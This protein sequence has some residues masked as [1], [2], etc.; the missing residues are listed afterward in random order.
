MIRVNGWREN[1][2]ALR[3]YQPWPRYYE[4]RYHEM[5]TVEALCRLPVSGGTML[6]LGCGNAFH[7]YLFSKSFDEIIAT[8]LYREDPLT[9]TIGLQRAA[10]V[11]RILKA[12]NLHIVGALADSLPLTSE[13]V[14]FVFSSNVLEHVPARQA[15]IREI[16][17][18]LR[19][20]AVCLT[21]VP[22]AMERVYNLPISYFMV[23]RSMCRGLMLHLR[24]SEQ[25]ASETAGEADSRSGRRW[26]VMARARRF[27]AKNYPTFPFPKPH[28][29]YRSS[30]EEFM[31]HRPGNWER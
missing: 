18:V 12:D 5:K 29:E 4:F 24:R 7:S 14:D 31:A 19:P 10:A 11:R 16:Y 20:N 8:D 2:E 15:A 13:S 28:G 21:I 6:E 26:G 30:T 27:L 17:R 22:A 1:L 25:A 23:L 3:P 9:H